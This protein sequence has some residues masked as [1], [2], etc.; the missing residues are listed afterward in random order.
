MAQA[1]RLTQDE[2]EGLAARIEDEE[3]IARLRDG[4]TT[5]AR[6]RQSLALAQLR[7]PFLFAID[8]SVRYLVP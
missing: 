2:F 3:A 5:A 4:W 8:V 7:L 1:G 6:R